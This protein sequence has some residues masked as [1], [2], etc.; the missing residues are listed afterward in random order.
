MGLLADTNEADGMLSAAEAVTRLKGFFAE[1]L[2]TV[3]EQ[4][5]IDYDIGRA[6]LAA[7]WDDLADATRRAGYL[8]DLRA[9]APEAFAELVVAGE[10][11]ARIARPEQIAETARVDAGLFEHPTEHQLAEEFIAVKEQ[12]EKLLSSEC[13]EYPRMAEL[14]RG[15]LPT[16]HQYFEDVMV[17]VED[18]ALCRNRLTLLHQIDQLFLRLADFLAI[19]HTGQ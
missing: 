16:I 17:M 2:Q 3:W 10:R 7:E 5:G 15:L 6:V 4:R 19:V 11:P 18:E 1:R 14:L 9:T 12:V 8:A 13:P